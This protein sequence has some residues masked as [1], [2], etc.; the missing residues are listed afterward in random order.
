MDV[1]ENLPFNKENGVNNMRAAI[2]HGDATNR[3][4]KVFATGGI[5]HHGVEVAAEGDQATCPAC[6]SIGTLFNDAYPAFTLTD[7][8]QILVEGAWLK[9]K[10]AT[11]P[12]VI[13]IRK[14]S[15]EAM[16]RG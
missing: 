2:R 11:H 9:C 8:R 15:C 7:G 1:G 12:R 4:G 14:L 3:G 13:A 10:C 6:N 5:P 16:T